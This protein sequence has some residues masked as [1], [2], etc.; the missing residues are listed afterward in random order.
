MKNLKKEKIG[1]IVLAGYMRLLSGDFIKEYKNRILNIHP[2]LLP[3]FK[4]AHG[5]KDALQ[6]GS[7]LTGVTVHFVTEDMDAG[8]IILQRALTIK[9]NDTER[10][11]AEAIHKEEH[12]MYP[13]AIQLFVEGRLKVES[14]RVKVTKD[15]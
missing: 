9:E 1:L 10:S 7:K 6:Y 14:G 15:L 8:P 3:S 13:Q 11:L 12:K 5:I 2:A 4:G